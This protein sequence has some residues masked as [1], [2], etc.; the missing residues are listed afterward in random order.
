MIDPL[1]SGRQPSL[2]FETIHQHK[3]GKRIPVEIFLQYINPPGESPRFVAIVRDV[4][5]RR[6]ATLRLND[7]IDEM[8]HRTKEITLLSELADLLYSCHNVSEAYEVITRFIPMLL[9]D[10]SGG[11]YIIDDGGNTLQS[12][13]TWG[14]LPPQETVFLP[15]DCVAVR[16]GLAYT[17]KADDSA[18]FCRHLPERKPDISFCMPLAAQGETFGLLHLQIISD[19]NSAVVPQTDIAETLRADF[20]ETIAKQ[21]SMALASLRSREALQNQSIRDPL[22]GLFNRRYMEE[23]FERELHRA[24]RSETPAVS[25]MMI[26]IDH[27]KKI[28]DSFGHDAGD[29]VLREVGSIL[30]G[31]SRKYDIACRFGGE[32]FVLCLPGA[33]REIAEKRATDIRE[34]VQRLSLRYEGR[35]MGVIT[36]SV[37]ISIYPDLGETPAELMK[38]ADQALYQAKEN[39]RDQVVV[40]EPNNGMSAI[41]P[42]KL[43]R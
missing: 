2:S 1:I 5:E 4:S 22:T 26:D 31:K 7:T 24:A 10:L 29:M 15:E 13:G 34:S 41:R 42:I 32:E 43:R 8:A 14:S 28:N 16:R 40:A 35:D 23:S 11:L 27:F 21:V 38:K 25:F 19:I 30:T 9:P 37:G 17:S 20:S 3:N 39:G 12:V 33:C 36:I 18:L 6:E